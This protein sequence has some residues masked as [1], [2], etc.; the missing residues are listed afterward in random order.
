MPNHAL[1]E[2]TDLTAAL[3]AAGPEAPTLC[4]EWTTN[5]L[6]AHLVLR[7]RSLTEVG[8]R[9]P[10]ARLQALAQRHIDAYVASHDYGQIVAAVEQGPPIYSPFAWPSERETV[11]LL[12]YVIHDEDVR[13]AAPEWAPRRIAVDR[14]QAIWSKLRMGA[15]LTLRSVPVPVR[16]DWPSHGSVSVGRG[17]SPVTITG[18]PVELA[19]VA[20]GRQ[21]VAKVDYDGDAADV[22]KV[23]E[24]K[25]AI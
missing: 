8:G 16:L 24:A 9:L 11:N 23:R 1:D 18:D 6:A 2:R 20:F 25:I 19:L 22:L 5:Q 7:E 12:E 15:R 13:R 21:R 4:G 10:V 17:P 14:Q 3:L